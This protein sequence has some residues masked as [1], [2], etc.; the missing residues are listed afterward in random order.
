[1]LARTRKTVVA[2]ALAALALSA[3]ITTAVQ[4]T[5]PGPRPAA[6]AVDPVPGL[7]AARGQKVLFD[8]D[9]GQLNDD[10]QA[11]Y[12]LTQARVDL[13]GVTTVSGNVWT[14]E[15]T[16]YALRQLAMVHQRDVPVYQGAADPLGGSRQHRLATEAKFYGTV[17]Y[18]GAWSHRE[19][20]DY[21]HLAQPPYRG[22]ASTA[23]A[24]GSAVDFIVRQVKAN[25][26]QVTL[27][28]LGPG[29][30]IAR[31]VRE[32]P[33]IVPLVKQV[34]YMNGAY[35]VPGNEGP[36]AEFNVWFDPQASKIALNT[37]FPKVT[38]IPL[39]VTDTVRYGRAQYERIARA[40]RTP[41]TQEFRDLQ[42][43]V[44]AKNPKHTQYIYDS[45]T[46]AVFLDPNLITQSRMA[47]VQ[48]DTHYDVDFGRTLGYVPAAAP[49][50]TARARIVSRI[51]VPGF[52]D[53]YVHLMTSPVPH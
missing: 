34:I 19:P 17:S 12:L 2:A 8:T 35:S 24:R 15:A 40:R 48:V 20:R 1:M 31:A 29:T 32:H 44:F 18:T 23:K 7:S 51:D 6:A 33:E 43:P 14:Q 21:R 47:K 11:L 42:G 9:F 13:L 10:S 3:A 50:R 37:P 45:L 49:V 27:F 36:A 41:I 16:A 26:H 52:F 38:I 5:D 53:L 28:V 46:A 22:Y 25:P 4:T 30:N 39:D